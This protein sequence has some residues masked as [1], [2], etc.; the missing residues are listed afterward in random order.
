MDTAARHHRSPRSPGERHGRCQSYPSLASFPRQQE[1][2]RDAGSALLDRIGPAIL[3][4]SQSGTFGWLVA[5][6]RPLLLK[7]IVAMEIAAVAAKWS[8][9]AAIR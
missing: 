6:A 7:A 2:N 3:L 4:T 9:G 5:D 1:L 8:S